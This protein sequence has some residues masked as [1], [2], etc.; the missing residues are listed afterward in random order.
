MIDAKTQIAPVAG[1]CEGLFAA[2]LLAISPATGG[3]KPVALM[4]NPFYQ[5]YYGASIF[6]GAE[7]VFLPATRETGFL[8]DLAAIDPAILERTQIF[9]L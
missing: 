5:V 8:P 6:A 3:Q 4:P 1:T 9:Y 7:P 2:A